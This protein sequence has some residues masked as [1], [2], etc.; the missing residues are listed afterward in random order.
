PHVYVYDLRTRRD[1]LLS[2]VTG[3][4]VEPAIDGQIVAWTDYR[5]DPERGNIYVYDLSTRREFPLGTQAAH[6]AQ[7][8]VSGQT[9]VWQDWRSGQA[10]IY[11]RDLSSGV[12]WP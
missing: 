7:P 6:Q 1:F 12:T 11:A 2:P 5:N 8:A 3:R 4:Q 9:V 10:Q